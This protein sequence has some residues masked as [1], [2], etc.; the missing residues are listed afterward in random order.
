M[1]I[2]WYVYYFK[3]YSDFPGSDLVAWSQ[4]HL[5]E[6]DENEC[7][8]GIEF[9]WYVDVSIQLNFIHMLL[10]IHL[11]LL[12]MTYMWIYIQGCCQRCCGRWRFCQVTSQKYSFICIDLY[13][14]QNCHHLHLLPFMTIKYLCHHH[15]HTYKI[16][17]F[18]GAWPTELRVWKEN[19]RRKMGFQFQFFRF[20]ST[21]WD[22]VIIRWVLWYVNQSGSGDEKRQKHVD[23]S[24]AKR[25][26][27]TSQGRGEVC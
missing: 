3:L 22:C 8:W 27:G 21:R 25:A 26:L 14:S 20:P 24:F 23:C 16:F 7:E 15:H 13:L 19:L 1:I 18:S 6:S 2:I 12:H 11:N 9:D 17:F 4:V 5:I 10:W